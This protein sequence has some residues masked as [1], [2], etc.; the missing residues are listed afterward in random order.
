MRSALD[1][2]LQIFRTATRSLKSRTDQNSSQNLLLHG[3]CFRSPT[4]TRMSYF[5][6]SISYSRITRSE[7]VTPNSPPLSVSAGPGVAGLARL[8]AFKKQKVPTP[9]ETSVPR[10]R[11]RYAQARDVDITAHAIVSEEILPPSRHRGI[12]GEPT[13]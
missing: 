4:T 1:R 8:A 11:N 9:Y 3:A 12:A 6:C 2:H 5:Q 13:A 10:C 7:C